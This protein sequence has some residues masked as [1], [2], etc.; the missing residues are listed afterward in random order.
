MEI[1]AG[2]IYG[3]RNASRL[4]MY[5]VLKV[6]RKSIILQNIDNP[7]S[8]FETTA[9]KLER[10]GY[11]RISQTPYVDTHCRGKKRKAAARRPSRCPYTLDFLE[12]RADC[13]K[14][15]QADS[16]HAGPA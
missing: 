6:T 11:E 2:E 12:G 14:P 15:V 10:S 5:S 4:V 16:V 3:K 7:L 13:E 9:E 1:R 8:L